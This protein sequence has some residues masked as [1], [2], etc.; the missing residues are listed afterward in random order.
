MKDTKNGLPQ[1]QRQFFESSPFGKM[2]VTSD[3]RIIDAN[4]NYCQMVQRSREELIGR[5]LF[6]V[7]PGAPGGADEETGARI[8]AS[9]AKVFETGIPDE[10]PVQKYEITD[11]DGTF[12]ERYWSVTH[13]PIFADPDRRDELIGVY[14]LA[15]EVT[16]AELVRRRTDAQVRAADSIHASQFDYDP[17]TDDF[18]RSPR[19]D[20][21]FGYAPGE[22]GPKAEALFARMDPNDL[23]TI[24]ATIDRALAEGPGS[25]ARFDYRILLPDGQT[26]WAT[27]RGEIV[28]DPSSQSLHL[29]GVILDITDLKQREEDLRAAV[30]QRD[31]LIAEV[32]HRVKNSLQLV[33]SI[34]MLESRAA[35]DPATRSVL[36]SATGRIQAIATIHAT[37]YQDN[38]VSAVQLDTYLARFCQHLERSVASSERRI[39]VHLRAEPIRLATDRAI[40]LS[41]LVNELVTNAFKHAFHGR[42]QGAVHVTLSKTGQDVVLEVRDDGNGPAEDPKDGEGG[43]GTRLISGGVAQLGGRLEQTRSPDG[44]T[45]RIHF[46]A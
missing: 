13:A 32:N 14:Q 46:D 27:A 34:L 19:V 28:R 42:D 33:T 29:V 5:K 9:I 41:L 38:D 15:N 37:L 2:A 44:W 11:P 26:R 30:E 18:R 35:T 12:R 16:A 8:R 1:I 36:M 17:V 45:T 4:H 7:F 23:P 39:A 3:L 24:R 40:T 20:A 10:L 43:L 31:L 6:T 21:M 25:L 22:A